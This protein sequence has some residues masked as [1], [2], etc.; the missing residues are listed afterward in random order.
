VLFRSLNEQRRA[1]D[2][3]VFTFRTAMAGKRVM[4]VSLLL[5]FTLLLCL[6]S[7]AQCTITVLK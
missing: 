3:A 2:R 1:D 4:I 7:E 6:L 5:C